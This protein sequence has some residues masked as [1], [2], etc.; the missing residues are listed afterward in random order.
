MSKYAES[1]VKGIFE[2]NLNNGK[3][4]TD[5]NDFGIIDDI[6]NS[7]K[8]NEIDSWCTFYK[9]ILSKIIY[10]VIRRYHSELDWLY[11]KFIVGGVMVKTYS[12]KIMFSIA[13]DDLN[14]A[15]DS[16]KPGMG[17]FFI[18]FDK[19]F[20]YISSEDKSNWRKH[21]AYNT[22]EQENGNI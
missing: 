14:W 1:I 21:S 10:S 13:H 8:G 5:H 16:L 11:N 3:N 18:T 22:W 19:N 2:L 9:K 17:R 4:I 12:N 6:F 15:E 7:P 20:N